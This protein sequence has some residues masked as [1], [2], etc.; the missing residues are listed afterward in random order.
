M[1]VTQTL[2]GSLTLNCRSGGWAKPPSAYRRNSRGAD[3]NRSANAAPPPASGEPRG[4]G[5]RTRQLTQVVVDLAV[6][7][8]P[9]FPARHA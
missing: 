5:H 1:S 8:D 9:R 3:D 6:A 4:A 7:V 2:F